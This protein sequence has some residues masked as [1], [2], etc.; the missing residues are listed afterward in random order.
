MQA[1]PLPTLFLITQERAWESHAPDCSCLVAS[2]TNQI[3]YA[4]CY[5]ESDQT[6]NCC[7]EDWALQEL[8]SL[9]FHS[10]ELNTVLISRSQ[11][12]TAVT[13]RCHDGDV[14]MCRGGTHERHDTCN[15]Q[16]KSLLQC[17]FNETVTASWLTASTMMYCITVT[18][19]ST[20]SWWPVN[21]MS[22]L[23]QQCVV[24]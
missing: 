18:S 22:A 13:V 1:L 3:F 7:K 4:V 17:Q 20:G 10:D 11:T 8:L 14:Y 15:K 5:N 21:K 24:I 19:I 23:S 16:T 12:K 6:P 9:N 2:S